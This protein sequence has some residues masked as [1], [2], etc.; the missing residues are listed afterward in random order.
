MPFNKLTRHGVLFHQFHSNRQFYRSPGSLDKDRFYK[1]I[2][3]NKNRIKNPEEF[4]QSNTKDNVICLTFDDGLMSQFKIAL[5][6]LENFNIKAFFFI[7]TGCLDGEHFTVENLRYFRYKFFKNS[8]HFYKIFFKT[9]EEIF[10]KKLIF[11]NKQTIKLFKIYKKQSKYY[12]YEDIIFKIAR[13]NLLSES[14]YKKIIFEM[15]KN[16]KIDLKSLSKKLY[17]SKNNIKNLSTLKH[18]IG[19]H[20]HKHDHKNHMYSYNQELNDYKKN[21][22]I[23]E[24]VVNKKIKCL[25]YPFGNYTKNSEKILKKL[26]IDYAFCKNSLIKNKK[27]N[28][29]FLPRENIS[30]LINF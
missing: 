13:D 28:N 23:L 8:S 4:F 11:S 16:Y 30:N 17:M 29:Y 7:F 6:V 19:L 12:T 21:K 22:I 14:E 27:Q 10:S 26:H 15:M 2:K 3:Q 9:H 25:S 5:D 1:F 24:K 18:V 20:S